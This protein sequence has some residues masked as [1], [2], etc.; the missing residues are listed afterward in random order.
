MV[1]TT[2]IHAAASVAILLGSMSLIA[3]LLVFMADGTVYTHLL[4]LPIVLF[5][6]LWKRKSVILTSILIAF[7]FAAAFLFAPQLSLTDNLVR[8][9]AF[10]IVSY[11][12][13]YLF[14]RRAKIE[15]ELVAQKEKTD[16]TIDGMGDLLFVLDQNQRV[17]RVNK[18]TCN[19]LQKKPEELLGK[20]C[21]EIVHGTHSPWPT[22]PASK[23]LQSN[24][25]VTEEINDPN[26]GKILLVT[27]SP[28]TDVDGR[29]IE[30]VH[31][32]KDI[33]EIKKAQQELT[34]AGQL[35]DSVSD[36]LI[37]HDL[38]GRII[39]FNEA[40]HQM[41]GYT[42]EEFQNLN[43]ANLQAPNDTWDMTAIIKQLEDNKEGT[44]NSFNVRKDRI[45]FP[46][47]VHSRLV[48]LEGKKFVVC[49]GR[50][51]TERKKM[52]EAL[53]LS[54]ARYRALVESADDA[55]LLSDLN[56]KTIYRNPAYY[57]QLGFS[58]GESD[59][60]A[61]IHPEDLPAVAQKRNQLIK[62]GSSTT[63]YRVKH[64]NGSWVYRFAR[65]SLIYNKR[66]MPYAVLSIIRDVTEQ[67]MVEHQLR[68]NQEKMALINEKLRVVGS[69]TRH[70]VRNKLGT[71][72]G[73]SYLIKKKLKDN[74]EVVDKLDKMVQSVRD[75]ERIFDFARAYERLG[76]E[77]LTFVDVGKAVNDAKALFSDPIPSVINNCSGL[78]VLADSFLSQMFYNFIDNT[79]KHGKKATT[80]K[81]SYE[82]ADNEVKLIYQDDGE[83]ISKENKP[84]LFKEGFSTAGSSGF[85]LFL[86]KKMIQVY[87]WD[88]R[89]DGEPGKGVR[90][91]MSI[92]K[93]KIQS[94]P[95]Q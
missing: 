66:Q 14:E 19:A 79:R 46:I 63:E 36:S 83:G 50:D 2:Y 28:L 55:I 15:K 59:D 18:A 53:G 47:E 10:L 71:I 23:T 64:R 92:P 73:Y 8:A 54:E 44:F 49:A 40:A 76:S 93:E 5:S 4:Y 26:L 45:V 12:T 74:P 30:C 52:E 81:I 43:V 62:T 9:A 42:K 25:S 57:R 1:K 95:Q 68:E 41:R 31:S 20:H 17:I 29:I 37:V 89:E 39:F 80:I 22:C 11:I 6:A 69:L 60:F 65:S 82:E 70:D 86:I 67:K 56:G 51:V 88:I 13:G 21:Y 77:E 61:Q 78:L 16:R 33:T 91:V 38:E 75:V 84:N 85:G 27:T 48:E 72:T 90:F 58:E 24:Q 34:I 32:A 94:T 87:G 35:F 7:L 3:Y